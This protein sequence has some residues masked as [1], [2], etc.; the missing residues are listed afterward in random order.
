MPQPPYSPDLAPS[1]LYLF[2]TVKNCLERIHTVDGDDLFE[3]LL[4]ILHPIWVDELEQVFT[5][6]IYR[7]RDVSEG[8]GDHIAYKKASRC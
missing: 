4:E 8:N 1:D 5:A 6:W 7:V 2:S 3:K